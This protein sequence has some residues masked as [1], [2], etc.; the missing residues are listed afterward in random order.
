[1]LTEA[2]IKDTEMLISF[3][4]GSVVLIIQY[5]PITV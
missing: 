1:M 2:H 3:K 5:F 4:N